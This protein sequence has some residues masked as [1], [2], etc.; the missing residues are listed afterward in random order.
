MWIIDYFN[1]ACWCLKNKT[2]RGI[3]HT[4]NNIKK[5]LSWL[6]LF[7]SLFFR[8]PYGFYGTILNWT[9]CEHWNSEVWPRCFERRKRVWS[10][11]WDG[12]CSLWWYL[13][14]H[15]PGKAIKKISYLNHICNSLSHIKELLKFD[16]FLPE[17]RKHV[18]SVSLDFSFLY[19]M[20]VS[21]Q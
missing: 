8:T 19:F 2:Q 10:N 11:D 13:H 7:L 14:F 15:F 4:Y 16:K 5:N 17:R 20:M 18:W 21:C 3:I 1:K 12:H 9:H 6:T